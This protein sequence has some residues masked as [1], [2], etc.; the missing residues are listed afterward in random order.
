MSKLL[1][2]AALRRRGIRYRKPSEIREPVSVNSFTRST[3]IVIDNEK[4]SELIP[5]AQTFMSIGIAARLVIEKLAR[6]LAADS[7]S[8]NLHEGDFE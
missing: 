5:L 7:P 3:P 1:D 8:A 2:Y 6:R 4:K